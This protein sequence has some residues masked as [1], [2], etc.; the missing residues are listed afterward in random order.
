MPAAPALSI[1]RSRSSRW[2]RLYSPV[3]ASVLLIRSNSALR[4]LGA[5][6][7]AA[8]CAPRRRPVRSARRPR[9]ASS[10]SPGRPAR[11]PATMSSVPVLPVRNTTGMS[12]SSS[13]GLQVGEHLVAVQPGHL[14][15]EQDRVGRRF[16]AAVDGRLTVDRPR[17]PC[18][19]H[20]RDS[21]GGRPGSPRESSA[22]RMVAAH[23]QSLSA[24]A[25]GSATSTTPSSRL[26]T[27]QMKRFGL[28][29]GSDVDVGVV[30][31][32]EPD[33][34]LDQHAERMPV[35][36]EHQDVVTA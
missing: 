16:V 31:A 10:G 27:P 6:P 5:G 20:F 29:V 2:R 22:T 30:D 35:G 23:G 34:L 15:V 21:G 3:R 14:D 32:A 24:R 18:T 19:P 1:C 28:A 17:R 11:S 9:T 4:S 13:L 12:S 25:A 8:W 7:A 26:I 33:D 36:G